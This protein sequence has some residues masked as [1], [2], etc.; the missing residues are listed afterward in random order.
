MNALHFLGQKRKTAKMRKIGESRKCSFF[1]IY[2]DYSLSILQ[3][4]MSNTGED[5][6]LVCV[7]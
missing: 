3:R 1:K 6:L 7:F 4:K 2:A 5:I